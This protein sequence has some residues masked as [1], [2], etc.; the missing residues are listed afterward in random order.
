ME[1]DK[2]LTCPNCR[3]DN[4]KFVC[5]KSKESGPNRFSIFSA[6]SLLLFILSLVFLIVI[7]KNELLIFSEKNIVTEETIGIATTA[8]ILAIT[9]MGFLT[10]YILCLALDIRNQESEGIAYICPYC[11]KTGWLNSLSTETSAQTTEP[12]LP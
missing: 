3:H 4:L 5:T 11:G 12:D 8:I 9:S 10:S 1:N 2:K 7:L 6:I